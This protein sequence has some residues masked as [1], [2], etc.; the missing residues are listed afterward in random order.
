MQNT[1]QIS[2]NKLMIKKVIYMI[3]IKR[4]GNF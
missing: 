3:L 2:F 4:D 1:N